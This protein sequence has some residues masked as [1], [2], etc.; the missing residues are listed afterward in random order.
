MES[1]HECGKTSGQPGLHIG[2]CR[3]KDRMVDHGGLIM[4]GRLTVS[5]QCA[6]V[7]KKANAI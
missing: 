4:D 7:A 1:E 2:L 6:F 3:G 5:Q